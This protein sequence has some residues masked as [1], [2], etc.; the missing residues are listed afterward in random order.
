MGY[1]SSLLRL[2]RS[3]PSPRLARGNVADAL[4]RAGLGIKT[5]RKQR[6]IMFRTGG[7]R[8]AR[9][10]AFEH[11][12]NCQVC[13]RDLTK[14]RRVYRCTVI[15]FR[16]NRRGAP[17]LGQQLQDQVWMCGPCKWLLGYD[18]DIVIRRDD[19]LEIVDTFTSPRRRSA[20]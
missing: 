5:S 9:R 10:K 1:M 15:A 6:P 7:K 16:S 19:G 8:M 11:E 12:S 2:E 20:S 13:K 17:D 18:A 14:E 4:F 3:V